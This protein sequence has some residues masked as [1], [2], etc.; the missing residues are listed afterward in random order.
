MEYTGIY[1]RALLKQRG[2][3]LVDNR[4]TGTS[5]LIDCKGVQDFAG[6]STGTAFARRVEACARQIERRHPGVHA[7][8]LYATAYAANDLAAV[9]EKLKLGRVDLYA[10]SYGTFF[11]QSFMA[12]HADLLHSVV[13]D[14]A[15]PVRDLDPWYV[16]SATVARGAMDAV[17]ARDA[18]CAAAAPGSATARLGDLLAKLRTGSIT[19]RTP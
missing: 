13:L 15:Y 19:G 1:G 17:C 14:S 18:G 4:G 5:D 16:S 7:A 10:D 11:S 9:I 8:D 12:R 2:L 3:L 6:V